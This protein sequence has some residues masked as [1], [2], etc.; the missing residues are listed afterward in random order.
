MTDDRRVRIGIYRIVGRER[1][2]EH[3]LETEKRKQLRRNPHVLNGKRVVGI[4]VENAGVAR[5]VDSPGL[6]ACELALEPFDLGKR[7]TCPAPRVVGPDH[8]E[9]TRCRVRQ[10]LEK[11]GVYE[12]EH[13]RCATDDQDDCGDRGRGERPLPGEHANGVADILEEALD[14]APGPDFTRIF[15]RQRDVAERAPGRLAR[16]IGRQA[17]SD[18]LLGLGVDMKLQLGLEFRLLRWSAPEVPQQK[19]PAY[20]VHGVTPRAAGPGSSRERTVPNGSA[21][22]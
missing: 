5:A 15:L 9:P 10:R 22:R 3:H 6:E 13:R 16:L 2:A 12:G 1:T 18:L 4:A 8:H 20:M 14:R 19:G 11:H 21:R 7:Q 17:L